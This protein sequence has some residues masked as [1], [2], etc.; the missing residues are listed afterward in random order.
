M[1]ALL[2]LAAYAAFTVCAFAQN[3]TPQ[4]LGEIETIKIYPGETKVFTFNQPVAEIRSTGENVKIAPESDRTFAFIGLTPG[5][6]ILTALNN[7]RQLVFRARLIVAG[8]AVRIYGT[9]TVDEKKSDYLGY[10]CSDLGCGRADA[11]VERQQS[12][13]VSRT[14]RNSRGD[15]ITTTTRD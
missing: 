14:R 15:I 10:I 5:S 12:G 13:S 4:E 3:G 11:E 8:N 2:A 1:R 6:S 9:S 7:E